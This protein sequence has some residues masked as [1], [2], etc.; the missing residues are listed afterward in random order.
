MQPERLEQQ[1]QQQELVQQQV[2]QPEQ[3]HQLGQPERLEQR[4]P[5]QQLGLGCS[6]Q[7]LAPCPNR[8][9]LVQRQV[10]RL[11]SQQHQPELVR[12]H[13][14]VLEWLHQPGWLVVRLQEHH[15]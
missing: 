11:G 13:Q 15:W 5:E 9:R 7:E 3:Q 4:Q 14:Q 6:F 8:R 10:Q 12:L 1:A 2:R